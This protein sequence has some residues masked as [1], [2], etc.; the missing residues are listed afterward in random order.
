MEI[1]AVWV[2]LITGA[3]D[4]VAVQ[5]GVSEAIAI[6]VF[7][8]L[9]RIALMPISFKSAYDMYSNKLAIARIKPDIERLQGLYKDNPGELARRTMALYK[10][11][12]ITLLDKTT[13]I[14]IASQG[15]LGLGIFHALK[16]MT[17]SAKFMWIG[18]IAK[19]DAILAFAVGVLTLL[20]MLA[21][22]GAAE[23]SHIMIFIIPAVISML[24]LASF[25]SAIGL[26]W[27]TSN[28]VTI[29]QTLVLRIVVSRQGFAIDKT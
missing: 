20:S 9:A 27:A 18:N 14:N 8:L 5:L 21:M 1:W 12:G 19:P 7:T 22:P 3:I 6:I 4:L 2:A 17:V 26:Y 24:V 13:L 16:N 11:N 23:Q 15:I 25:P 29:A 10:K 28:L